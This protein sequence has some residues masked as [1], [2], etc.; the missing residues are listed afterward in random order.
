MIVM[1]TCTI[2]TSSSFISEAPTGLTVI[3]TRFERHFLLFNSQLEA[4]LLG[5]ERQLCPVRSTGVECR[6]PKKAD[7]SHEWSRSSLCPVRLTKRVSYYLPTSLM[8]FE[9]VL[10]VAF[11]ALAGLYVPPMLMRNSDGATTRAREF[12]NVVWHITLANLR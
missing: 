1:L 4:Q 7:M 2:S 5:N 12:R 10:P 8:A 3:I 9:R 6:S 11:G